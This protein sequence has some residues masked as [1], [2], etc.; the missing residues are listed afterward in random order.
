MQKA[1]AGSPGA[2]L[3]EEQKDRAEKVRQVTCHEL[4]HAY[5]GHLRLPAWLHEGLAMVTVD[6]LAGTQTVKAE[7]LVWAGSAPGPGPRSRDLDAGALVRA[8][9]RSDWITRYIA[10]TRPDL[11]G[12]LLEKRIK[13]NELEGRLAEA[14]GLPAG[15]F[16]RIGEQAVAHF[17]Q[18]GAT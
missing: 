1:A 15:G 16:S 7:T 13:H 5:T 8:Y 17:G 6:S 10:E 18:V 3:F 2:R 4:T 9:A 12:G 14:Y 11:L